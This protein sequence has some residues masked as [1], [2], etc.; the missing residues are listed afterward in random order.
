MALPV[1][2][3]M[4]Y[5]PVESAL[6]ISSMGRSHALKTRVLNRQHPY[7]D[8]SE[9]KDGGNLLKMLNFRRIRSRLQ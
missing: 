1:V 7:L 2:G 3:M 4:G 5:S 6:F 8:I 9:F